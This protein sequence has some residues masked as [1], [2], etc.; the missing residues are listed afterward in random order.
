MSTGPE[1]RRERA[2]YLFDA[3]L[4]A[5]ESGDQR[6]A[7][8]AATTAF[9][10]LRADGPTELAAVCA[11]LAAESCYALDDSSGARGWLRRASEV[12]RS[13]GRLPE[14]AAC[15]FDLAAALAADEEWTPAAAAF[16]TAAELF[17]QADEHEDAADAHWAG[18]EIALQF[19]DKARARTLFIAASGHYR[20]A[21]RIE[22]QA[23]CEFLA[24]MADVE[25]ERK[26]EALGRFRVAR[27]LFESS[28]H[29]GELPECDEQIGD[30]LDAAGQRAAAA[31]AL[32]RAGAG[33]TALNRHGDAGG[34]WFRAGTALLA[35]ARID[36]AM[37]AMEQAEGAFAAAG[38]PDLGFGIR[39]VRAV[40]LEDLGRY[41]EAR[42]LYSE[43]RAH[44]L[45]T[46]ERAETAWCDTNIAT[47]YMAEGDYGTAEAL[48]V[49]A[50]PTLRRAD[51]A[52]YAKNQM[53]LGVLRMQQSRHAEAAAPIETALAYA[54]RGNDR[55]LIGDC[56]FQ[57]AS[58]S[59]YNGAVTAVSD[60]LDRAEELFTVAGM[61]AK[62]AL[63]TQWRAVAAY[64]AGRFAEA[65]R[66][67]LQCRAVLA[68]HGN[69]RHVAVCDN[70][71]GLVH[72]ES[73]DLAAA[74]PAF[75]RALRAAHT[76]GLT[77]LRAGIESNLGGLLLRR[78][79]YAEAE[80]HFHAAET[81]LVPLGDSF[82]VANCRA[83]R[84]GV[85][86]LLGRQREAIALLEAASAY[87]RAHPEFHRHSA[88]CARNIAVAELVA[89]DD[90]TGLRHLATARAAALAAGTTL[91]V[92]RC[93]ILAAGLL[94]GDPDAD[95]GPALDLA[96][97]A[98]LYLQ[99]Q[100]HQFTRAASRAAWATA[101]EEFRLQIVRWIDRTADAGLMAEFIEDAINSSAF[102]TGTE[103]PPDG[104]GAALAA[105]ISAAALEVDDTARHV[106]PVIRPIPA[107]GA[108]IAGAELPVRPPP[109]LR[110]PDGRIVLDA[111][112][113]SA[114]DRYGPIE[115]DVLV[116]AW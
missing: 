52:R 29:P 42:T 101:N 112:L 38:R 103:L 40:A 7:V 88:A 107:N 91:E 44:H 76:L 30:L 49:G 64:G 27:E 34:C 6:G 45:G 18:A 36:A 67:L 71:L 9:E 35:S 50:A 26:A 43:I 16:A 102:S 23:R 56:L 20:L 3:A 60:D 2:E 95:L 8:I 96:L 94:A 37:R 32:L 57:R 39:E 22:E 62:I 93:D 69:L 17:G 54:E 12:N 14:A 79:E 48:L 80:R 84:G 82:A 106:V 13:I 87:F 21:G 25:L 51:P 85:L 66:L 81:A 68:A 78:T 31:D 72:T 111:Y 97:P 19:D 28:G 61:P 46:G 58:V 104:P 11:L 41:P 33:Y 108:L 99:R 115:R 47:T 74:E 4:G 5:A 77:A 55:E 24:A 65:A 105:E 75:E 10:L 86:V 90:A 89:G 1:D 98:V 59:F 83:N 63:C 110:T 53:F 100:R 15:E 109:L 116:G 114:A 92:A 73:G 70:L 113:R